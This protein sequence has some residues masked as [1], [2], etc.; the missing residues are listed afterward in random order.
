MAQQPQPGHGMDR[1]ATPQYGGMVK[2]F[3]QVVAVVEGIDSHGCDTGINVNASLDDCI[4][5]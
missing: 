5:I 3:G 4:E 1:D 2:A